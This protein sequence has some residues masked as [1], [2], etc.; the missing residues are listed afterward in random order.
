MIDHPTTPR[1][2]D[3]IVTPV[4]FIGGL[5]GGEQ[6]GLAVRFRLDDSALADQPHHQS[7]REGP[8]DEPEAVYAISELVVAADERVEVPDILPDTDAERAAEGS[9]RFQALGAHS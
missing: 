5:H 7:D 2:A 8:A 4:G 3:K 9:E 1:R 6:Q